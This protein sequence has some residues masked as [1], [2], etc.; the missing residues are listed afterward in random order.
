MTLNKLNLDFKKNGYIIT[1]V[2]S[3]INKIDKI[4]KKIDLLIKKKRF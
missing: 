4:N 3:L 1:S 2:P